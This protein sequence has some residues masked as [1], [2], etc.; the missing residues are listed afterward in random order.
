M[1]ALFTGTHT[2][3]NVRGALG[4]V[5]SDLWLSGEGIVLFKNDPMRYETKKN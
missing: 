5:L 1:L 3:H 2:S 4:D